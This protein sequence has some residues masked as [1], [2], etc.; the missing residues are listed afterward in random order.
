MMNEVAN[1]S[2]IHHRLSRG[3]LLEMMGHYAAKSSSRTWAKLGPL[4]GLSS[5][6]DQ[7]GGSADDNNNFS[8]LSPM[9][10]FSVDQCEQIPSCPH[11]AHRRLIGLPPEGKEFHRIPAP[12]IPGG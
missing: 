3:Y 9:S 1:A 4:N 8:H 12:I 10:M 6:D 7:R 2:S 11:G 5:G